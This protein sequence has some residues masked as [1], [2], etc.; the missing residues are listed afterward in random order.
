MCQGSTAT[1]SAVG[2]SS[3]VWTGNGNGSQIIVS[4]NLTTTY[5]VTVF[6]AANCT[7]TDQVDVIVLAPPIADAGLDENICFGDSVVLNENG[8]NNYQWTPGNIN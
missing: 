5:T 3:F 4:P 2:A 7:A 8:G 6:S 1:I